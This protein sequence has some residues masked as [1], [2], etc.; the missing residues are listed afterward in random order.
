MREQKKSIFY[1]VKKTHGGCLQLLLLLLVFI[2]FIIKS[3]FPSKVRHLE[4]G[5]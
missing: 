5:F 1:L 4:R 3:E 2:V